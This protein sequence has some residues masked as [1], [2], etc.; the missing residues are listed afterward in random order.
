M[1]KM[2][3]TLAA[4]C[5]AGAASAVTLA[6]KTG[7]GEAVSNKAVVGSVATNNAC[8][9]ASFS[10]LLTFTED[11]QDKE[12]IRLGLWDRGFAN[13]QAYVGNQ[14]FGSY[15]QWASDPWS[16]AQKLADLNDKTVLFTVTCEKTDV[17]ST[18]V[19]IYVDGTEI[20]TFDL[21]G[22]NGFSV[23]VNDGDFYTVQGTSAY[24]GVLTVEQ[25]QEM[26]TSNSVTVLPE[27]TAL[28]L[29]ALGVAGL[30]LRRKAA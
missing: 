4:L 3:M 30:A 28:A 10:A 9:S 27:P 24:N 29:L 16:E 21:T 26:A 7:G 25:I 19:R 6:W 12:I 15:Y 8:E 11:L 20:H 5:V 14:D 1:K 2:M 23:T 22:M 18:T 13:I 17:S